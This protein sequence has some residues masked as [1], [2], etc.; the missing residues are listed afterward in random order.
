MNLP[1]PKKHKITIAIVDDSKVYREALDYYFSQTDG[2]EVL[3]VASD[4]LELIKKLKHKQPQVI[5]LDINMPNLDGAAALKQLRDKY[6]SLKFIILTV[7]LEQPVI[8]SFIESGA[9]SFLN[10]SADAA[11]IHNAIIKCSESDF[12]MNDWINDA[13][14]PLKK[15]S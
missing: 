15:N 10:K 7:N 11:E 9:N 3:F 8:K 14:I 1:I 13:L 6:P 12:Y 4:G 5:L 2:I